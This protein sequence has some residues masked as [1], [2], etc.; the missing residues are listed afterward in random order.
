M[1]QRGDTS[2]KAK[3]CPTCGAPATREA[4]PFCSKRCADIDL[5]RWFQGAYA[6]P[7]V[8]AADDSIV[9]AEIAATG[10]FRPPDPDG[11]TR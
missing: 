5:G 2:S 7:A 11:E 6:I 9:D 1:S 3:K 8:D 10:G 4:R